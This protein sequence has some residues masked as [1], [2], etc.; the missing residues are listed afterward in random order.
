MTIARSRGN[1]VY[2]HLHNPSPDQASKGRPKCFGERFDMKDSKTWG[3]ADET[4]EHSHLRPSGKLVTIKMDVWNN[5]LMSGRAKKNAPIQEVQ[6]EVFD[7]EMLQN[8]ITEL[9]LEE[10]VSL[11]NDM[12]HLIKQ[13]QKEEKKEI[14]AKMHEM[15]KSAGYSSVAEFVGSPGGRAPRS[16]K[17]VKLP[18]KY[19]SKDGKK[20]WSGKGRRPD[21]VIEHLEAGGKVE[22][23]E[24][25]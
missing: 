14:L 17:G 4:I 11:R 8:A 16:D 7:A 18:P 23:L 6:P 12:D 21:W 15:A 5:L 13:K 20:T 19:Q 2:C 24:I 25:S 1:R 22:A 9:P 3:D 10:L